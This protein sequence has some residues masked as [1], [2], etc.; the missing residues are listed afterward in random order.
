MAVSLTRYPRQVAADQ[1]VCAGG[2]GAERSGAAVCCPA[3]DGRRRR[4]TADPLKLTHRISGR[5]R[6]ADAGE[7]VRVKGTV[8]ALACRTGD[9]AGALSWN[10][11]YNPWGVCDYT[12]WYVCTLRGEGEVPGG[13]RKMKIIR[14]WP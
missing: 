9:P 14:E 6:E 7:G 11:L 5:G 2:E 10:P 1:G 12:L 8:A 3:A 4:P 13:F